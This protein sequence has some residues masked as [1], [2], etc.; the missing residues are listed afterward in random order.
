MPGPA[1]FEKHAH[2][3]RERIP[4]RVVHAKGSGAYSTHRLQ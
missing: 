2:F 4:K 3:N 1:L